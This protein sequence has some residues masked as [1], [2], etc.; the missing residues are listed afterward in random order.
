MKCFSTVPAM[1]LPSLRSVT[2]GV[3]GYGVRALGF[4]EF[5]L[6][7]MGFIGLRLGFRLGLSVKVKI[8]ARAKRYVKGLGLAMWLPSLHSGTCG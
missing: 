4:I 3:R 6:G 5:S 8:K 1:W 2:Y 7:F